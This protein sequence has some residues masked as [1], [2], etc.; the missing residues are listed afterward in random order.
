MNTNDNPSI[1]CGCFFAALAFNLTLGT[2]SVNY[3]SNVWFQK[4]I[5]WYGD[6]I[7]ALFAAEF[8]VPAAIATWVFQLF[9]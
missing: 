1:T 8:T 6:M 2:M 4:D 7:V 9:M 3:I 5:P